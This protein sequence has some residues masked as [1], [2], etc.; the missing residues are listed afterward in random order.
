[1]ATSAPKKL[2][3]VSKTEK[4]K[5]G[6]NVNKNYENEKQKNISWGRQIGGLGG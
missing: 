6:K 1:L 5:R 4:I 2:R 3:N